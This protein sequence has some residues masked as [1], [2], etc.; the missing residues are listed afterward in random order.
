MTNLKFAEV[1]R[2]DFL[3]YCKKS[4]TFWFIYNKLIIEE[5]IRKNGVKKMY[6][7]HMAATERKFADIIW[8]NAPVKSPQLVKLA[9]KELNWSKSTTY[10]VLRKLCQKGIFRNENALVTAVIS[11]EEY[12]GLKT[13][14]TVNELY[15]GSLPEFIAAYA[16]RQRVSREE[17]EELL[18]I[19]KDI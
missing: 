2:L 17:K 9:G 19:I 16:A 8:E 10:T 15:N 18:K 11:R 4:L 1:L 6:D 14:N 7:L 13:V 12:L 5:K 3:F